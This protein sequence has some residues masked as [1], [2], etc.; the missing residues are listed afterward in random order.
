MWGGGALHAESPLELEEAHGTSDLQSFP[1]LN[2][3]PDDDE[4]G[5]DYSQDGIKM[6]LAEKV[7]DD[8]ARSAEET[9]KAAHIQ[10]MKELAT[11]ASGVGVVPLHS[12]CCGP[13]VKGA[14]TGGSLGHFCANGQKG[15]N[16]QRVERSR[17]E[18]IVKRAFVGT[19][20]IFGTS[21]RPEDP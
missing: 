18:A 2:V 7:Q 1:V 17:Q 16:T 13:Q 14:G 3:D 4:T 9:A 15:D 12:A 11:R 8:A 10:A 5:V 20:R 19:L 21:V 6:S